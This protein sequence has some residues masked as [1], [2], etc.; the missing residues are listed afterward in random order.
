[1]TRAERIETILYDSSNVINAKDVHALSQL[2]SDEVV[3][4]LEGLKDKA[5]PIDD[6]EPDA[7]PVTDIDAAIAAEKE[8]E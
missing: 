4:A 7:V 2:I 3:A 8:G 1:M 5:V 6:D